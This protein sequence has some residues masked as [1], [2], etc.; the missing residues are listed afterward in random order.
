MQDLYLYARE[1]F[2]VTPE[3]H[4]RLLAKASEEKVIGDSMPYVYNHNS[5]LLFSLCCVLMLNYNL[6]MA[7]IAITLACKRLHSALSELR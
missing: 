6:S 7:V 5:C 4:A 1:A 3:Q 2:G